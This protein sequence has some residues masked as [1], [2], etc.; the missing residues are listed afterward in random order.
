MIAGRAVRPA[1]QD[2]Q[3]RQHQRQQCRGSK[4]EVRD[5]KD[6]AATGTV[7]AQHEAAVNS[8]GTVPIRRQ[9]LPSTASASVERRYSRESG[10]PCPPP[11]HL[12]EVRIGHAEPPTDLQTSRGI[13]IAS[14]GSSLGHLFTKKAEVLPTSTAAQAPCTR[15][16][17]AATYSD[18]EANSPEQCGDSVING[19]S[20]PAAQVHETNPH[21]DLLPA[22]QHPQT[23]QQ[24]SQ[25]EAVIMPSACHSPR[26]DGAQY[27]AADMRASGSS[28]A[29][30]RGLFNEHRGDPRTRQTAGPQLEMSH[31]GSWVVVSPD[32]ARMPLV[33]K[34][35]NAT[36]EP[37]FI[38][39]QAATYST[40]NQCKA[41]MLLELG[42]KF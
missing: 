31:A 32:G 15:S 20:Q 30:A 7:N 11:Q 4:Q 5:P 12:E 36:G 13:D 1:A 16:A 10:P 35:L 27:Q 23:G 26:A 22:N 25:A 17:L 37:P 18:T 6:Q 29:A 38:S 8:E 28:Y 33:Q 24:L 2:I 34:R 21:A 19:H 9:R 42:S 40:T 41:Y 3:C 14:R 39:N